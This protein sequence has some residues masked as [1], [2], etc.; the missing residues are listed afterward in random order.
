MKVRCL[1]NLICPIPSYNRI[2]HFGQQFLHKFLVSQNPHNFNKCRAWFHHDRHH[3]ISNRVFKSR[4]DNPRL[5]RI[6]QFIHQ[7]NDRTRHKLLLFLRSRFQQI[8][9]HR[10]FRIRRVKINDILCPLRRN[11]L[12]N[13]LYRIMGVN[14][15]Y[16]FPRSDILQN[17]IHQ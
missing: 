12:Q 13:F 14:K 16:S 9:S 4:T 7:V 11:I 1:G 6:V 5:V 17:H 8:Q 2:L 10:S 3:G 15:T